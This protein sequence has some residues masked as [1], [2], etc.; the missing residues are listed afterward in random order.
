[1]TGDRF[2]VEGRNRLE[3]RVRVSGNKN[4]AIHTLA[5]TLL[6]PDDCYLDNVPD[7]GDIRFMVEILKALG[8]SVQYTS[9]SS[10]HVNAAGVNT[11]AAPSDLATHLRGSFLVMGPLLAR[12][13]EAA[14][15]PQVAT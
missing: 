12:F 15:C 2:R 3:G 1:M 7:I 4:A 5:A 10:L 6:T 13:G 14:C 8:A 9:P 11:L